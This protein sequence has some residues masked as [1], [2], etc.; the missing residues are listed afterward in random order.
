MLTR[1]VAGNSS[2]NRAFAFFPVPGFDPVSAEAGGAQLRG[3][4]DAGTNAQTLGLPKRNGYLKIF[5]VWDIT[6]DVDVAIGPLLEV[7][8]QS[9]DVIECYF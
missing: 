3:P 1:D 9:F 2:R 4:P 7:S 8:P 5:E 6:H